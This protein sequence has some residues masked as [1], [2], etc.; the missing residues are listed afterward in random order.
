LLKPLNIGTVYT[1]GNYEYYEH[2]SPA[3]LRV[4]K[5]TRKRL[6]ENICPCDLERL[7][8]EERIAFFQGSPHPRKTVI[9]LVINC[10]FFQR[11]VW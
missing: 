9:A 5:K 4:R 11:I 6:K 1:D 7:V 8:S 10:W 2:F 3:V